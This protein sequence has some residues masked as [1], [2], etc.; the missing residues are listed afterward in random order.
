MASV[1][2]DPRGKSKFWYAAYKLPDGRRQFRS[3]K[4]TN[5]RGAQKIADAWERAAT[6]QATETQFR[7][8]MNSI[9]EQVSG[10]PLA[11]ST[12]R[13]FFARLFPKAFHTVSAQCDRVGTLSNQ[14]Y[15]VMV[16][17]GLVPA[18]S[19]A[20]K[21]GR[22]SSKRVGLG[23]SFHCLRHTATSLMKEAGIPEATVRDIIGHESKEVS[24]NYTHVDEGA[25]RSALEKYSRL[26]LPT[27][28]KQ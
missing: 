23:L 1:H 26:L 24:A 28:R 7:R 12:S 22:E 18:R 16:E 4:V 25:K 6:H 17:A 11:S 8:V 14:F 27:T 10:R 20:K 9:W 15:E 19:H 13:D 5:R 21:P 2:R 3:T